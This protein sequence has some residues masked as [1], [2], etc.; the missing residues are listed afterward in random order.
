MDKIT[1]Y[2]GNSAVIA[3]EVLNP[4]GT[5]AVLSGFTATL[6]VKEAKTDTAALITE[7]GT[8][9]GNEITFVIPAASNIIDKGTYY[10]EVV[11]ES[12]SQK[13]T[14]AHE[15]FYVKESLIYVT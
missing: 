7:T 10:Y 13:L 8:I 5:D 6:N 11:L 9:S 2:E 1:V 14:V 12:T 4:D 3:F 15:R